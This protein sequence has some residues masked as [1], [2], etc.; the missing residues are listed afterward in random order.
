[1]ARHTVQLFLA[2]FGT[3]RFLGARHTMQSVAHNVA[4]G[5]LNSTSAAVAQKVAPYVRH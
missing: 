2:T 4:K 5:W 3:T 1:M